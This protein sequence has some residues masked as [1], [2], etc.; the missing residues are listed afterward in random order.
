MIP[1]QLLAFPDCLQPVS[2]NGAAY[3]INVVDTMGYNYATY[4]VYVGAIAAD[5]TVLKLTEADVKASATALTGA[6]DI[7]GA[8][9]GTAPAPA[10]ATVVANTRHVFHVRLGGNR[11]RYQ[12]PAATAGAGATGAGVGAGGWWRTLVES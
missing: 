11:K 8:V 5:L 12:L 3:T 10:L 1:T 9:F 6:A 4:V 7:T 2:A